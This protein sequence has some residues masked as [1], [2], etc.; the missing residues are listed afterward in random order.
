[1]AMEDNTDEVI[2]R[3]E[4]GGS[5]PV[6]NVQALASKDPKDIPVRYIR[7]EIESEEVLADESLQI[8]VIDISK[9]AAS[10]QPGYDEELAKLFSRGHYKIL[11][12][13]GYYYGQT[14]VFLVNHG[15][16]EA[17]D[18]MKKV[19]EE[20]FKLPL[21]EKMKYAQLPNTI[22]GYGQAFVLSEEQKLDWGDML[23]LYTLA[24]S[25]KEPQILASKSQF[26][27]VTRYL[28]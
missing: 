3:T 13:T 2:N 12:S 26:L 22:E 6:D 23:F 10:G 21:D 27:Q 28:R 15:I 19:T 9:L 4:Y 7:P 14:H 16:S 18:A 20:F 5:I 11:F 8:P 17:I 1:M 24:S 25:F